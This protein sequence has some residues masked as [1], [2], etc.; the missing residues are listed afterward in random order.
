L[1]NIQKLLKSDIPIWVNVLQVL[2]TLIMLGQVYMY[3]F[4]HDLLAATGVTVNGTPDL[5]LVYE[6]GGRTLTMAAASIFVMITQNAR[7]FL[8]VLFMNIL[9]EGTETIIDPLFPI[10][11]APASPA[12]DFGM[13]V[14]VV[15]IEIL[16][17][18]MVWKRLKKSSQTGN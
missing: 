15:A 2:L 4:D 9:R 11:N 16:A 17:C 1:H 3:F 6:M 18:I 12:M 7:Q 10:A 5:N 8:V 14:V 13:H